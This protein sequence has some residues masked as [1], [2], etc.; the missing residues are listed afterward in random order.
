[1]HLS[2][3]DLSL[4]RLRLRGRS[5]GKGFKV[6]A[7]LDRQAV[8]ETAD[9]VPLDLLPAHESTKKTASNGFD[10]IK[11]MRVTYTISKALQSILVFIKNYNCIRYGCGAGLTY[12]AKALLQGTR[13]VLGFTH[14]LREHYLCLIP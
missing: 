9:L 12:D 13:H 11:M 5:P 1:M 6:F 7:A 10:S 2:S 8:K 4:K 14:L 3:L